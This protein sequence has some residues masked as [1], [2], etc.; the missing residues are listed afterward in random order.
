MAPNLKR[1]SLSSPCLA[2]G[3]IQSFIQTSAAKEVAL[4]RPPTPAFES[5]SYWEW[6]SPV[7]TTTPPAAAAADLFSVD[8]IT[9][10]LIKAASKQLDSAS[11]IRASSDDY[12]AE[13]SLSTSEPN[14]SVPLVDS[15]SYFAEASH[16]AA[17]PS[18]WEE[19]RA[20]V[21][22]SSN[23][24]DSESEHY[25]NEVA[26]ATSDSDAYWAEGE[27]SQRYWSW[28]VDDAPT[29]RDCYWIM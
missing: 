2:G 26:H 11:T 7:T 6:S 13:E 24:I 23:V 15:V 28:H 12:W 27:S 17:D 10:N 18:Y 20:P 19:T 21:H 16:N 5:D 3:D 1:I 9:E 22:H 4:Y 25:W 14:E 29:Q 8:H